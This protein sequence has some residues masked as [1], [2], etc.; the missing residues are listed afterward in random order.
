MSEDVATQ[1]YTVDCEA[2]EVTSNWQ[3]MLFTLA[4]L[5]VTVALWLYHLY[6][7][8][9]TLNCLP[10]A[11]W[12]CSIS[13]LWIMLVRYQG[14]ENSVMLA[15]H[16]KRGAVLRLAPNEIGVGGMNEGVKEMLSHF[17]KHGVYDSFQNYNTPTLF[18]F[19]ENNLHKQRRRELTPIFR[20]SHLQHSSSVQ[21]A[22]Q[23][24][25][26]ERL[27]PLLDKLQGFPMDMREINDAV[28]ADFVT[29]FAFGN[30]G[31]NLLQN[32][33]T[34][35]LFL[36]M[37]YQERS[38]RFCEQELPLLAS[39]LHGLGICSR[40]RAAQA[41]A[42]WLE[43][44]FTGQYDQLVTTQHDRDAILLNHLRSTLKTR[45]DVIAEAHDHC[46]AGLDNT[47][48]ILTKIMQW[49][50]QHPHVQKELHGQIASG[51]A[52][53][54]KGI[55]NETLRTQMHS[56]LTRSSPHIPTPIGRSLLLPPGV[57]V[58]IYPH[59]LQNSPRIFSTPEEFDPNRWTH[60][61]SGNSTAAPERCGEVGRY[62]LAFGGG[63]RTCV[64][65]DFAKHVIEVTLMRIYGSFES[66]LADGAASTWSRP[67][68]PGLGP[69]PM[70]VVF[71]KLG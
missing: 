27:S 18:T 22:T 63:A 7:R 33:S 34:R 29:T 20:R 67:F 58:T 71:E 66:R 41:A 2:F 13:P 56:P 31:T 19:K 62:F 6:F 38:S 16:Q 51:K 1:I 42:R 9:R 39:C 69:H 26:Q 14:K 70:N 5:L 47:G 52:T 17:P 43:G 54:L 25:L 61:P 30:R 68:T 65:Q 64:G 36:L 3:A 28:A 40:S 23:K 8:V 44:W 57:R 15:C 4:T 59:V 60:P 37:Y 24:I 50:S 53:L 32:E 45:V 46:L 35:R 48:F 49:L 12:T 10:N 21:G 55:I 11:H